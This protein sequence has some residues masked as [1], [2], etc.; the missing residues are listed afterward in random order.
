MEVI[1]ATGNPT[2]A[3]EMLLGLY[4]EPEIAFKNAILANQKDNKIDIEYLC[5]DRFKDEVTFRYHRVIRKEAWFRKD[6]TVH[7]E[8][9]IASDRYWSDSAAEKLKMTQEEF[10][11][12]HE[13]L[14]YAVE[15]ESSY[16]TSTKCAR[17][18]NEYTQK[19]E[20]IPHEEEGID[21]ATLADQQTEAMLS[22]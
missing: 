4:E 14:E 18:W 13:R 17:D 9:T 1:A 22:M 10:K 3:S 21:L 2:V 19:C 8:E 15:I 5:Y 12:T 20:V 6:A 16:S 11:E 7:T